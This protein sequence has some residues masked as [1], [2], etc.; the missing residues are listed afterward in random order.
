MPAHFRE[1]ADVHID[2]ITADYA[3]IEEAA[4]KVWNARPDS[5]DR[6]TLAMYFTQ[7]PSPIPGVCF[8]RLD[9]KNEEEGIWK[10]IRPKPED[11]FKTAV[12]EV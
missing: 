1:W 4:N 2:R 10:A 5:Q 12:V 8:A 3:A 6:K 11:A 9:G 7:S